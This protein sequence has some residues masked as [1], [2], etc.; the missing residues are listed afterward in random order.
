VSGREE[1]EPYVHANVA[2]REV[3]EPCACDVVAVG[4]ALEPCRSTAV[5]TAGTLLTSPCFRWGL[6]TAVVMG[7]HGVPSLLVYRGEPDGTPVLFPVA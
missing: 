7:A 4:G 1:P 6:R 2:V 5:G 3:V